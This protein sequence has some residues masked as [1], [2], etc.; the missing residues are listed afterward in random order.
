VEFRGAWAD[1]VFPEVQNMLASAGYTAVSG[2][3]RESYSPSQAY[4][5]KEVVTIRG[6]VSR[7]GRTFSVELAHS[8]PGSGIT[9]QAR[10]TY[11]SNTTISIS[12]VSAP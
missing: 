9:A 11:L 5:G 10:I 2:F 12:S 3:K 8:P 7:G 4:D 1:K 6:K